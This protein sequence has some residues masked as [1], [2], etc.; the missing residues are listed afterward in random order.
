MSCNE[1]LVNNG[2]AIDAIDPEEYLEKAY[3]PKRNCLKWGNYYVKLSSKKKKLNT[4]PQK[5]P[6]TRDGIYVYIV[7]QNGDMWTTEVSNRFEYGVVHYTLAYNSNATRI[8]IAGELKKEGDI[9]HFNLQSGTYMQTFMEDVLEG[10]CDDYLKV[11]AGDI[12]Q[13][14]HPNL[15]H[16]YHEQTFVEVKDLPKLNEAILHEFH[17]NGIEVRLYS[18]RTLCLQEP[19]L[20]ESYAKHSHDASVREDYKKLLE[21][22]NHEYVKYEPTQKA[23]GKKKY[24][25]PRRMTRRYCKKTPCNK[26]GFTQKA[27]CR[28]WKNCYTRRG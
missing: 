13:K 23:G 10:K 18:D 16:V 28:P 12:L 24:K 21:R 11:K 7:D 20:L 26:M 8:Q 14:H 19:E 5:G 2:V 15:K 22:Y 4:T 17:S 9:L 3:R 1:A 27:S 25:F 6:V